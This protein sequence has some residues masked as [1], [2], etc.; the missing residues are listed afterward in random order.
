MLIL[1]EPEMDPVAGLEED[2]RFDGLE[3]RVLEAYSNEHISRGRA[4]EL[5]SGVDPEAL[6]ALP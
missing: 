2:T 6:A 5:L 3:R 4:R 1:A